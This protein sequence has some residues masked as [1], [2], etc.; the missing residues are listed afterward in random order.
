[1]AIDPN[2][3]YKSKYNFSWSIDHNYDASEENQVII[4]EGSGGYINTTVTIKYQDDIILSKNYIRPI[5][6]P[7]YNKELERLFPGAETGGNIALRYKALFGC[8]PFKLWNT[9]HTYYHKGHENS[10]SDIIKTVSCIICLPLHVIH[11]LESAFIIPPARFMDLI[12]S[13]IQCSCCN[14]CFDIFFTCH[15]GQ[16]SLANDT[17]LR[18]TAN[19]LALEHID[20]IWSKNITELIKEAEIILEN[21][22]KQIVA[23]NTPLFNMSQRSS[24][25]IENHPQPRQRPSMPIRMAMT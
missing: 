9:C 1:M 11:F 21:N 18:T 19:S 7:F 4:E 13:K 24:L 25:V 5:Y 23:N 8:P 16:L 15:S 2:K 12:H 22:E 10:G 17:L 20:D 3:F 6:D 14:K